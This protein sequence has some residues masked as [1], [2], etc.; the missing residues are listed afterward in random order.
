MDFGA[1]YVKDNGSMVL[2]KTK[3]LVSYYGKKKPK[4]KHYLA[5]TTSARCLISIY[6]FAL[7][8]LSEDVSL[9]SY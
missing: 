3:S 4:Y 1:I 7:S 5:H 6:L 2:K 9:L 8:I